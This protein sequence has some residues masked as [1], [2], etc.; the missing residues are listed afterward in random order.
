[1]EVITTHLNADFDALAS[2]VAAKK[3]Y[4]EAEL[5]FSGSQEK[6][7]RN[8]LAQEFRNLYSFKRLRHID[9]EKVTRLIV[10]DTRQPNRIGPLQDCL[11]NPNLELHIYDHHP[12]TAGDMQ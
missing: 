7:L 5:V 10:V 2:M 8:F 9:L 3:L 6:V 12:D 11:N 4:P 1:M